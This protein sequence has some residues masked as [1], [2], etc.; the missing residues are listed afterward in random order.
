MP[1]SGKSIDKQQKRSGAKLADLQQ[2]QAE[3]RND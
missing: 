3:A 1:V 2:E